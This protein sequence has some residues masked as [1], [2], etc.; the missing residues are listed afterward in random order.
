VGEQRIGSGGGLLCPPG[1]QNGD[2][3][4]VDR[5]DPLLA[6]LTEAGHVGTGP[7]VEIGA[8]EA[9]QLGQT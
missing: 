8:G 7:E 4:G 1:A 2:R 6:A 3:S 5:G 9:G